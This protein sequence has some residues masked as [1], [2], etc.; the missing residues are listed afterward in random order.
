MLKVRITPHSEVIRAILLED[1]P[2]VVVSHR[3]RGAGHRTA[4]G[5]RPGAC[6]RGCI[7]RVR[8]GQIDVGQINSALYSIR[9][10]ACAGRVRRPQQ[11]QHA[12]LIR[13]CPSAI[14]LYAAHCCA[15]AA[16]CH[17]CRHAALYV[18][19]AIAV[20]ACVGRVRVGQIN[21]GKMNSACAPYAREASV[22]ETCCWHS[23]FINLS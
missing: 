23:G 22:W 17:V 8:V 7:G 16:V 10:G 1:S 20:C 18:T 15:Y 21:V 14:V 6:A 12:V 2:G 19:C 3:P 4:A 11:G 9:P 5:S 13:P